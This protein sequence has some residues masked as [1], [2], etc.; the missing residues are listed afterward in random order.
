VLD[1]GIDPTLTWDRLLAGQS[2]GFDDALDAFLADCERTRCAY[3]TAVRGDLGAAFDRLAAQVE[4]RPLRTSSPGRS[5]GPG[6]LSL[7]VGAGLYSRESGW[8]AIAAGLVQ[9][10]RG[11]GSTLLAL[12]DSYL[13]RGPDGYANTSEAN[14]A[15][16]CIDR[17]WPRD[18]APYL[19]LASRS[20]PT[21]RASARPSRCPAWP[22]PTGRSTRSCSR[23]PSPPRGRRRSWSSGRRATRPRRTPGR[24][25][26][27][28]SSRRACC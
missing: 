11:D 23:G 1:G 28:T 7:G 8:P 2:R 14:L 21:P 24:S 17:P 12:N 10:E 22:A 16:N 4:E 19:A 13:E 27:P 15:V 3:R 6:E 26:S 25:R 20:A 18:S 9:A 5:V